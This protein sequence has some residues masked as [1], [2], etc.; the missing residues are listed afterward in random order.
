MT[1]LRA[2]LREANFTEQQWRVL[3]VLASEG[4]QDVTQLSKASLLHGPSLARILRELEERGLIS[5]RTD[6]ID[7]RRSIAT[8]TDLGQ[9]LMYDV[10]TTT[11]G[12]LDSY[13]Q[14][15]GEERLRK[16]LEELDAFTD[17]IR[18]E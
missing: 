11:V 5:R 12:V 4:E 14:K 1:P 8:L 9:R 17:A 3:R 18:G 13:A 16:L 10:W 6:A 2:K 15:F 7:G